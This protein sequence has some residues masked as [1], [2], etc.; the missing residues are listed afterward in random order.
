M[1]NQVVCLERRLLTVFILLGLV[2]LFADMT[3]E[4]A[5]GVSG[6]YLE[7][8]KGTAVI[9]GAVT[10]GEFLGYIIRFFSGYIADKLRK[11]SALWGLTIA[12]Y[13][14]NLV[15]V[16]MLALSGRWEVALTL[17][18]LERVGK[19]LRAPARDVILSE[20]VEGI[21][22]GRGFGLHEVMDQIG[23]FAGPLLV[24]W[25]L[26]FSG[27]DYSLAF[28]SLA[29][30]AVASL[31]CLIIAFRKYPTVKTVT[32]KKPVVGRRL[33]KKFDL[34][35]TSL[36]LM[37]AGY[38]AWSL[39]SYH[40]KESGLLSDP[41]ISLLYAIAMGVDALVA[42]PVGMLYD[43]A[44]LKSLLLTPLL[45]LTIPPLLLTGSRI[46]IYAMAVVWG[47]VMAIYETNMRAAIPDLV[48]PSRRAFAYGTYGVIYGSAWML[49]SIIA[50][51]IYT[52]SPTYLILYSAVMEI[53]SLLAMIPLLRSRGEQKSLVSK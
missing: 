49:G 36:A 40:V 22:K 44:G 50:G 1:I 16:P 42:L 43:K 10:V 9:A 45:A 7:V 23:A 21:G 26:S 6:A 3:Y 33:G 18:Y 47:A 32:A 25:V 15:A 52:L 35:S 27:D 13:V 46:S 5:R 41:E 11:S 24:A 4:G 51:I 19:G 39:I 31:A 17:L 8:L 34:F 2:S 14:I 12:G 20:V 53:A 37:T 28:A 30:P 38:I 48:D 29:F